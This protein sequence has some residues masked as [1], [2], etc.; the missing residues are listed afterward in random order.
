MSKTLLYFK[1]KLRPLQWQDSRPQFHSYIQEAAKLL[2]V[3]GGVIDDSNT[4]MPLE[5]AI[6][7]I[8]ETAWKLRQRCLIL[9]HNL[10][11]EEYAQQW[12]DRNGY[13]HLQTVDGF[14]W[15]IPP[16]SVIPLSIES[17]L[18]I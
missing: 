4:K 16:N 6:S 2:K 10:S 9:E 8:K 12:C 3:K 15:A 14:W 11:P 18:K 1:S 5:E 17:L 7:F 13:T